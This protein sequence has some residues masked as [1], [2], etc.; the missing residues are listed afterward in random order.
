M[1]ILKHFVFN[2]FEENTYL[3][4]D[5]TTL[6]AAVVDA[7]MFTAKDYSE[8]DNF[9]ENHGIHLNQAI[10]THLHLDHCFGLNHVISRYGAK[11]AASAD[12]AFLGDKL[13][14]QARQ[15]GIF[16]REGSFPAVT[17]DVNL[18]D[19][20][21]IE[22]G[23][24]KLI[25]IASPGHT[26]GGIALYAPEEKFVLTGD[27]LFRE[28]IGRTDLPGGDQA[29]L[30]SSVKNRLLALPPDTIVYPGH[31]PRT[32]VALELATNPFIR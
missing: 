19:G 30:V 11:L 5:N 28:S 16:G 15:F 2:P 26:P 13:A 8:F 27:S 12:D 29:A 17:I 3:I 21:I 4:I 18:K 31:G 22:I 23:E 7:G 1:L 20:D 25:V 32:T 10:N 9:I 24:G 14:E 6:D